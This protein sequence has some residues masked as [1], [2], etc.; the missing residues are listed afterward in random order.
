MVAARAVFEA[1]IE[2]EMWGGSNP[3]SKVRTRKVPQRSYETLRFDEVA[4]VLEA[5]GEQ[6]RD[7]IATALYLGLRKGELFALRKTDILLDERTLFVRRSHDRRHGEG[8]EGASPADPLA[9]RALPRARD[10]AL[11]ERPGLPA[12][13]R[14]SAAGR[15]GDGEGAQ[16]YPLARG[17]DHRLPAHLPQV[18]REWLSRTDS[19]L[20][21]RAAAL[22]EVQRAD[23]GQRDPASDALPRL[24][25]HH[26]HPAPPQARAN[27][28]AIASLLAGI[29]ADLVGT[30]GGGADIG[31]IMRE[32][33]VGASLDVDGSHY[34]DIHHTPADTLDKIDPKNLALCVA[35]MAVVAYTVA[36]MPQALSWS[37]NHH[38]Q[39]TPIAP[40]QNESIK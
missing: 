28:Q 36:D 26:G 13:R 2:A 7:L 14:I 32:G 19:S 37:T 22:P 23:V 4:A 39:I 38:P 33:V 9:A 40:I 10:E 25:A 35:T 24:A 15:D 17:P 6:W 27:L 34:F 8:E 31:P 3:A 5:A 16:A 20:R 1:A 30:D 18:R 12:R 21:Q 29:G 11:G